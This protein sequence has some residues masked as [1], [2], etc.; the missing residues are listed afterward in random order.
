MSAVAEQPVWYAL[1]GDEALATMEV[2]PTTGL[3]A[4]EESARLEKYGPNKFAE[5]KSEA[6]WHVFM[7]QYYD[8]MQIVLLVAGIGSLAITQWGTG[9]V[10]LGLTVLNAAL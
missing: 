3:S 8:V 1:S 10:V 4:A 5:G 2:D 9:I 7:R 6:R